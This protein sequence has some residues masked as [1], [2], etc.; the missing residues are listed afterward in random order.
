MLW[1]ASGFFYALRLKNILVF[2]DIFWDLALPLC[3]TLLCF[4]MCIG[5]TVLFRDRVYKQGVLMRQMAHDTYTAYMLHIFV[6]LFFQYLALGLATPPLL[7][8]FLVTL[9]AVPAS[10]LIAHLVRRPLRL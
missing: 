9:V 6:V 10:F 1:L 2:E 5:L 8:F 7:K 4:G 3:E